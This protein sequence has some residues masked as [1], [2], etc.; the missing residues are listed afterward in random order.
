[1]T[2]HTM[3]STQLVPVSGSVL[4]SQDTPLS[5]FVLSN[6]RLLREALARVLRNHEGISFV[7]AEGFSLAAFA[8][9]VDSEYDALLVDPFNK[10]VLY[11][12]IL[13]Q[14][15]NALPHLRIISIDM[16]SNVDDLLAEIF[17]TS[18]PYDQYI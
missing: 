8:E 4:I 17:A 5:V 13:H 14:L 1:M 6:V 10:G 18:P 9:I 15:P 12:S 11:R 3:L 7:R 16:E 2:L